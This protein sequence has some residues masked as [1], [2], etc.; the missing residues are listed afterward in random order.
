MLSGFADLGPD[1]TQAELTGAI[2]LLR[3][4]TLGAKP[5]CRKGGG[6]RTEHYNHGDLTADQISNRLA[7]PPAERYS[8]DRFAPSM[9]PPWARP[10]R[11]A[12][13]KAHFGLGP[14][15]SR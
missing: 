4:D 6:H 12:S 7:L 9:K 15:K 1:A 3:H 8:M 13:T 10:A 2:D 5:A 11:N 14:K